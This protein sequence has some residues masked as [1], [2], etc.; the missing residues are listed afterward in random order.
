MKKRGGPAQQSFFK[1]SA[2]IDKIHSTILSGDRDAFDAVIHDR[3]QNAQVYKKIKGKNVVWYDLKDD[4]VFLLAVPGQSEQCVLK[5][6]DE[7]EFPFHEICGNVLATKLAETA[8]P[9]FVKCLDV[10]QFTGSTDNSYY[11][12]MEYFEEDTDNIDIDEPICMYNLFYQVNYAI[13]HMSQTSTG[14]LQH[15]D[16]RYDNIRIKMLPKNRDFFQNGVKTNF[17][18]KV[19]DWGQC[20]FNWGFGSSLKDSHGSD[21]SNTSRPVNASVPREAEYAAKWGEYPK[22]YS[23]YDFQY[24]L[25]TLT[26]VLDNLHGL[27]YYY[28]YGMMMDHMQ[29]VT[30]TEAQDRPIVIT[31]KNPQGMLA[32]MKSSIL[33]GVELL[34]NE[35]EAEEDDSMQK[36]KQKK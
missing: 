18:I 35:A 33:P 29:P 30:F 19:G 21:T 23:N 4:V 10:G 34:D 22:T 17:L 6:F 1:N 24:F 15:F 31:E 2:R 12:L 5:V 25:S 36:K 11:I 14:Q 9:F 16:L 8:G 28:M 26:P 7:D 13:H 20:E 3:K 32:F 27:S